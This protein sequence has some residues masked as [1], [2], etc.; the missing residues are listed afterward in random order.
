MTCTTLN[1][2]IFYLYDKFSLLPQTNDESSVQIKFDS[3]NLD[4]AGG[5]YLDVLLVNDVTADKDR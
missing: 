3:F 1:S 5:D 2:G 4:V